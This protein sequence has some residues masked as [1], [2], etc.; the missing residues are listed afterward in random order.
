MKTFGFNL[1]Q[2]KD[3]DGMDYLV[4][5]PASS[6]NGREAIIPLTTLDGILMLKTMTLKFTQ[7]QQEMIIQHVKSICNN[8][9]NGG[10]DYLFHFQK[11]KVCPVLMRVNWITENRIDWIIGDLLT[12]R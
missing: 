11:G 4:Y 7:R 6:V 10:I 12:G 1:V 5:T 8:E 3:G 9:H 2:N